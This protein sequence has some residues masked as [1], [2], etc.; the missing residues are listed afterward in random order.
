MGGNSFYLIFKSYICS[1]L[2]LVLISSLYKHNIVERTVQSSFRRL[3]SIEGGT[4]IF[5]GSFF[6]SERR[7]PRL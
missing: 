3:G 7:F 2:C 5:G 1:G 6:L 4:G